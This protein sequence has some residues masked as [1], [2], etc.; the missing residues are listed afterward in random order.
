[1]VDEFPIIGVPAPPGE[2]HEPMGT[3]RKFWA[4]LHGERW[5]FKQNRPAQGEDWSEK[6]AAEIA[7]LLDVDHSVVELAGC[8]GEPG[9]VSRN[10]VEAFPGN[11]LLVHGNELLSDFYA[12]DYPTKQSYK[13]RQH[14]IPAVQKVLTAYHLSESAPEFIAGT[15]TAL[16]HL[17]TGYLMLDA[18]VGNTDRHHENW[19]IIAPLVQLKSSFSMADAATELLCGVRLAPSFDHASSLGRELSDVAR[20][21]M[22]SG[23]GNRNLARYA[24]KCLS[25]IYLQ[26]GEAKPLTPHRAFREATVDAP[27][28]RSFWLQRLGGVGEEEFGAI[29]DRVPTPRMSPE[30]KRFAREFLRYNRIRL[31]EAG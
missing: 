24:E 23:S 29:I 21:D 2:T 3:K 16:W 18:L 12:G 19:A 30:A 7:G 20:A 9:I 11:S 28:I 1:M 25:K 14:C 13:V 26:D 15:I 27:N 31:L 8:E 5:L 10:F 22:L 6:I 17:F 4:T